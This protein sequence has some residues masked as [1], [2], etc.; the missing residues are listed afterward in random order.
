M[1][2]NVLIVDDSPMM[3]N[4]VGRVLNLAGLEIAHRFDAGNGAEA[5]KA[6]TEHSVDLVF[7]DI[8][9]PIMSGEELVRE[10][11]LKEDL[12]RL[13]VI[14]IS[15]DGTT[16]R[17]DR[18]KDLGVFGYLQKPFRPEDLRDEVERV[19][20]MPRVSS[21]E[22]NAAAAAAAARVLETMCFSNVVDTIG[23]KLDQQKTPIGVAVRF[24]GSL[25]GSLE[26]WASHQLA[27]SLAIN[28]LGSSESADASGLDNAMLNELANMICGAALTQLDAEGEFDLG[29]PVAISREAEALVQ[30]QQVDSDDG[31]MW[32][33]FEVGQARRST[34]AASVC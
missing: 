20:K 30:G 2:L 28:F 13:P 18:M 19:M 3:R 1:A 32:I 27:S 10:M 11:S 9:M 6:M 15:T 4:L 8:N 25:S 7:V 24:S 21:G 29:S 12:R 31:S 33:F 17:M 22:L 23:S 16:R 34:E 14:V 5:L 26:L